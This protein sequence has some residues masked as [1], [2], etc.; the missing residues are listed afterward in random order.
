MNPILDPPGQN[1]AT[2]RFAVEILRQV[3]EACDEDVAYADDNREGESDL[4]LGKTKARA[5]ACTSAAMTAF[6]GYINLVRAIGR[7]DVLQLHK[8]RE[9]IVAEYG[10]S[11]CTSETGSVRRSEFWSSCS[12]MNDPLTGLR[13]I[14]AHSYGGS[15]SLHIVPTAGDHRKRYS[16]IPKNETSSPY[17][18]CKYS[19]NEKIVTVA[20]EQDEASLGKGWADS[21]DAFAPYKVPRKPKT[22]RELVRWVSEW[23]V[24]GLSVDDRRRLEAQVFR[25][26][27]LFWRSPA[28][29]S[30][31][32]DVMRS[33]F[34]GV[35]GV[36]SVAGKLNEE[37]LNNEIPTLVL[38]SAIAGGWYRFASESPEDIFPER[39]GHYWA[40]L[41]H[42][43]DWDGLFYS[44][45]AEWLARLR[46]NPRQ[47]I[48]DDVSRIPS[49]PAEPTRGDR[50]GI[51]SSKVG[52]PINEST[53]DKEQ[54][55]RRKAKSKALDKQRASKGWSPGAEVEGH[56]CGQDQRGPR[57]DRRGIKSD[58]QHASFHLRLFK[59]ILCKEQI[60]ID[61]WV[62]EHHFARTSFFWWKKARMT[63]ESLKKRVSDSKAAEIEKA[64]ELHAQQLGLCDLD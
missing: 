32:I 45:T 46:E 15:A 22:D 48:E 50:A 58:R 34:N 40:W 44:E 1:E 20:N 63:G 14:A 25:A 49:F 24:P 16:E 2:S 43:I 12:R 17:P 38:D 53:H 55:V 13:N 36:L 61:T 52:A 51:R 5:A 56:R 4:Y 42:S 64:I 26:N 39:I 27:G 23:P 28:V 59:E 33:L 54:Y 11:A 30:T 57:K 62:T 60:A 35:A 29:P 3:I 47:E 10:T 6:A 37:L 8:I 41:D 9:R 18:K 31:N 19:W 21:P 7:D